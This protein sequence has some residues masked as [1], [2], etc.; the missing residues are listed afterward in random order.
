MFG[1][2]GLMTMK[3]A[4]SLFLCALLWLCGSALAQAPAA[5]QR[6]RGDLVALDGL[7]LQVRSRGGEMLAVTL[8]ENYNV[9]AVVRIDLAAIKQGAFIGT[10]SMAQPDG[11]LTALEVLVF[12][13]AMRGSGEGHYARDLK[14]GSMMT[15]ATVAE[16]ATLTQTHG[17]QLSLKYKDGE[18]TMVV[19]EDV[20]IVTFEPGERAMLL[21]GAHIVLTA[22][23]QPDGSLTAGRVVVGKTASCRRCNR[24]SAG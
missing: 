23:K 22:A 16:V 20:P 18:K 13:E 8:A 21:P 11:T 5:T 10:A 2:Q 24:G 15:K 9:T 19:P 6:I 3:Q 14:P 7:H 17:R 12:P 1:K 4:C